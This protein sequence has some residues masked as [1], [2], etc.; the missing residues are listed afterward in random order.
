M[1]MILGSSSPRRKQILKELGFEFEVIAP[2]IDEKAIRNDDPARLVLA[3]ANAKADAVLAKISEPAIIIT[4]DQV[5][6]FN[7][8]ILEKPEDTEEAK[9]MLRSYA[10][11]TIKTVTSVVVTNSLTNQRFSGVDTA[12][13]DL[14]KIPEEALEEIVQNKNAD[15]LNRAGGFV[16]NHP[17][18]TPFIERVHG[19]VESIIGLPKAL[20]Q[21][22]LSKAQI[23]PPNL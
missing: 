16:I 4:S 9:R 22:L 11:Q 1:R 23:K 15:I 17:L 12:A 10:N 6:S 19:E 18:V 20:T 2:N 21:K 5:V 13:I 8:A 3:L 7:D 14:K